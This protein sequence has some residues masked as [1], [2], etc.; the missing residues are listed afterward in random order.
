MYAPGHPPT[1]QRRVPSRAWIVSMRVL[2]VVLAV[3]SIGLLLWAPLLRLAIVRRRV[4]DGWL[5]GG[6]FVLV[7]VLLPV[8]GRDDSNPEAHGIDYVFIPLL[9][10]AII[11]AVAYYLFGD[12]RH[13]EQLA[14]EQFGGGYPPPVPGYGYL[15][16]TPMHG[17][18]PVQPQPQPYPQPQPPRYQPQVQPPSAAQP[19]PARPTAAPNPPHRIDQVRAE[20]DELSDYLRKEQDR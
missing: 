11:G 1:P 3:G 13:Y 14:K 18:L 9:F 20:L 6:G 19:P 10:L 2:F 7:C 5:T 12:I 4:S 16:T 17:P 8:I 15:T